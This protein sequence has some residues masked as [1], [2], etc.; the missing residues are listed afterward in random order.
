MN[1]HRSLIAVTVSF[2]FAFAIL[3]G[4]TPASIATNTE[5][6][7]WAK[8]GLSVAQIYFVDQT[9]VKWPVSSVTYK[10]NEAIGV[11][12]YYQTTCP[13]SNLHCVNVSEYSA[14]DG[15]YGIT[16]WPNFWD[17]ANHNLAGEFIT[18]NDTT[19]TNSTQAHKSTCQEEGHVLGLDHQFVNTSCMMQGDAISLGISMYP[20][21][22][23]FSE[24]T[25]IY[26]HTN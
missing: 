16:Y 6:H 3:L 17:S 8:D 14:N 7:H 4:T 1:R 2:A 12:S 11:N 9:G 25:A 24:L 23:D 22:H 15:N 19:V 10:W 26:N 18:L 5:G 21:A 20:N 13:N